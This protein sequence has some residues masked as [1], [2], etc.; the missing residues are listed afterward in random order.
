MSSSTGSSELV[1]VEFTGAVTGNDPINHLGPN[2]TSLLSTVVTAIEARLSGKDVL[3]VL[4]TESNIEGATA[5]F[6]IACGLIAG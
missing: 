4:G 1:V 5:A 6:S 2:G 3:T